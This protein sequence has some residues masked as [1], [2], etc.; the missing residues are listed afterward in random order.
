[1][2]FIE[3]QNFELAWDRVRSNNGCEGVDGET[4]GRF[5]RDAAKNLEQLR[6]ALIAGSYRPLPLRQLFVPKKA[7]HS[8]T[9]G[10]LPQQEWRELG[11]PAVRDRLVQ[12][13][14]LQV[15]HPLMEAEFEPCSF[16]YRPGRSHLMAARQ[17]GRWRDRGYE[18]VLDADAAGVG[19][20]AEAATD[21][22]TVGANG[23][24]PLQPGCMWRWAIG[25]G[26]NGRYRLV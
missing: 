12:Q 22:N 8:A 18:W 15:L 3:P 5:K 20:G 26:R 21:P 10:K 19:Q 2:R 17:V 14:L 1:M 4:I 24:L 6:R 23:R 11:I 13:A 9:P 7:T 25:S 16:A